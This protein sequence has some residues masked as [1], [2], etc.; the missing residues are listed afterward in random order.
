MFDKILIANR[1]EIACRIARTCRRL[2]IATVAVYSEADA[3]APHVRMADEA[4]LLGAAPAAES[5]LRAERICQAIRDSGA[6]AVHPG[7]GFLAENAAFVEAVEAAGAVFIGPPSPAVAAMG[8]KIESRRIAQAAGLAVIPGSGEASD[9]ACRAVQAARRIGYPVMLKAAAGGGGKGMRTAASDDEAREGFLRARSE[10]QAAFGDGRIFVEKLIAQPRHIEI[11]LLADGHGKVVWLNERECSIQRRHQ[12]VIEEAPSP[13]LDAATRRA[14]GEKA[15]SLARAVGYRSAGTVE[16]VCDANKNFYFL[17]MNTRLQVEHPVT[18]AICGL[19]LVEW[20]IRIAAG[21]ALAFD[22]DD[23]AIDG[24]AIEARICAEDPRRGFL[25][26]AGRLVRY[27]PPPEGEGVRIDSGVEEG[28]E[29]SVFYDPMLAKLIVHGRD[30]GDAI[31]RMAAALDRFELRGIGHNIDFL[32]ALLRERRFLAGETT[33][34]LVD[35]LWPQGFA[36]APCGERERLALAG[37][38]LFAHLATLERDRQL[39]A[40][41]EQ[42]GGPPA[43]LGERWSLR[44]AAGEP[45]LAAVA[46]LRG[47]VLALALDG[48]GEIAVESAWHPGLTLFEGRVDGRPLAFPIERRNGL[49]WRLSHAGVAVEVEVLPARAAALLAGLP[50]RPAGEGALLLR[51]PMPGMVVELPVA[52]GDAVEAGQALAVIEA[53]KMENVLRAERAA[54]VAEVHVAKGDSVAADQPL[55]SFQRAGEAGGA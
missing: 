46:R 49:R 29:A 36:G 25:P 55:L 11:Q 10:A 5:Y 33:T 37:A 42:R 24:W 39:A 31:A 41:A 35:E 38:A 34:A 3:G 8:D 30:R 32:A 7:F 9:D 1:G 14:M 2:G 40:G 12:K 51:S 21:E 23:V 52:A 26:S 18:E 28:S 47:S 13:L 53:M 15:A 19:D 16:F 17:E 50:P 27:R 22:Q 6:Q 20:M 45:P 43:P 48:G 54:K 4:V 44:L